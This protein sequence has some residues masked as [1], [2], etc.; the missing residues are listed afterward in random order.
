[1]PHMQA[2]IIRDRAYQIE[3][4]HGTWIVP[5]SVSGDLRIRGIHDE[6]SDKWDTLCAALQAYVEPGA[7]HWTSIEALPTG[8]CARMS[9]PGYL[10]ATDWTHYPTLREARAS[11]REMYGD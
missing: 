11:L 6:T 5:Q 1:M 10:D 9:A 4:H 2:D 3:T 7:R 8:Y